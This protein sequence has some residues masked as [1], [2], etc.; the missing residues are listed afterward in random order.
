MIAELAVVAVTCFLGYAYLAI[1]A[2]QARKYGSHDGPP[3]S[4]P[5]V[6][7]GDGRHLAYKERGVAKEEA[8]YKIIV[9]HGFGGSKDSNLHLSQVRQILFAISIFLFVKLFNLE[10]ELK[11]QNFSDMIWLLKDIL[12]SICLF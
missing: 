6:K 8:K 7:L 11:F 12:R 3:V 2:P 4:S 5:R 1:R 9:I 10:I